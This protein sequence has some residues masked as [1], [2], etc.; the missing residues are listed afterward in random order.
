[1]AEVTGAS[2]ITMNA[3]TRTMTKTK[4]IMTVLNPVM[5]TKMKIMIRIMTR[6]KIMMMK[7]IMITARN[8]ATEIIRRMT[9]TIATEGDTRTGKTTIMIIGTMVRGG[10]VVLHQGQAGDLLPRTGTR[11]E[12]MLPKGE[13]ILMAEAAEMAGGIPLLQVQIQAG[14]SLPLQ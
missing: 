14:D 13:G 6:M 1:M 2:R 11:L 9:I 8:S 5:K 3:T 4:M 7:K 10:A 12:D